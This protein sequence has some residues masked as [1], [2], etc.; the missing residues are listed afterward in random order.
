[1]GFNPRFAMW[2][3]ED[4]RGYAPTLGDMMRRGW[5]LTF[6]CPSCRTAYKADLDKIIRLKGPNWSPW[7]RT[8]PCPKLF[9]E[10]R[11]ALRAYAARPN[12]YIEI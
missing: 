1:M 2:R 5:S 6:H 7:G 8:A 11:M 9:C 4:W 3:R 12:C 10:G